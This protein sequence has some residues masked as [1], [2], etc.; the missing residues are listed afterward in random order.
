MKYCHVGLPEN[1]KLTTGI[2]KVKVR[3]E[4]ESGVLVFKTVQS[5]SFYPI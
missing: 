3:L 1:E 4:A 2:E 5:R